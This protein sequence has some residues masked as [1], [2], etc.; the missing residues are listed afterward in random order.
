M[1]KL[2][3][4]LAAT[5]PAVMSPH[6]SPGI[7]PDA[8][9]PFGQTLAADDAPTT[10]AAFSDARLG[11]KTLYESMHTIEVAD[12]ETRK[13]HAS[14]VVVDGHN[15]RP[16]ISPEK[17][18]ELAASMGAKWDSVARVFDQHLGR[19]TETKA[20]L[21][22]AI[23]KALEAPRKND[24]SVA[25]AA[26]DIR[27]YIAALPDGKRMDFLHSAIES[28][29]HEIASA[30]LG[31][32]GFVSGL[33]REQAATIRDMASQKFAPRQ[34][35]QHRALSAVQD[36]MTSAAKNWT[37]RFEALLPRVKESKADA[38]MKALKVGA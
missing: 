7:H 8:I 9:L 13:Q 1:S 5:A 4:I 35:E 10:A 37:T 24:T 27:R 12:I 32:A 20:N 11:L 17:A 15:V 23:A 30:V 16:S 19:V 38:A 2:E 29:D 18:A 34:Y 31:T 26:S 36:A 28:G 25:Q 22:T 3:G 6:V 21:E 33:N 14:G